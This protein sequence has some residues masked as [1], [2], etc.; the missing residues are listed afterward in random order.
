M[1]SCFE[2]KRRKLKC[3]R[4]TPICSRCISVGNPELC[5]YDPRFA[6]GMDA[7]AAGLTCATEE[8][9]SLSH[10]ASQLPT[11]SLDSIDASLLGENGHPSPW[12]PFSLHL[13]LESA[14]SELLDSE[15]LIDSLKSQVQQHPVP[16]RRNS[17][18]G[19]FRGP[20]H[21]T[22]IISSFQDLYRFMKQT[23]EDHH[24]LGASQWAAY[25]I[26]APQALAP[27]SEGDVEQAMN[28]L[29]PA[30]GR[31]RHL[32]ESYFDH[33][34]GIHALFHTPTFWH[35][36]RSYWD[37]SHN[38]PARFNATLLAVLSCAR[39]LFVDNPLSFDGDSSSA[40]N[41][42]V[43]WLHAVE[44][45]PGY[46]AMKSTTIEAFQLRC[47]VLFSKIQNDIDPD[48]HYTASQT[49]LADAVSNGLHRDWHLLGLDES[50]YERELRRK[51][52]TAIAELDIAACIERGV[53]SM[54][55]NLFTDIGKPRGYN[56]VDYN[57]NSKIEPPDRPDSQLTDSSF[58]KI[59][60]MIRPL[61]YEINEFVNNP[62]KH[63]SLDPHRLAALRMQISEALDSL[64]SWSDPV[65]DATQPNRGLV[66]RAVLELHLHELLLLLHLP[67]A[68][69]K[70][71]SLSPVVDMDFKRFIC[72]RSACT[73][74]KIHELVEQEGFSPIAL[75][76]ASLLRAGLCL[77]LFGGGQLNYGNPCSLESIR[78]SV[79]ES[80]Q[81]SLL[82]RYV[83][84]PK[85]N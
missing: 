15:N 29:L 45:W 25:T 64:P 21:S 41:E 69:E 33:F 78:G 49:L 9:W 22:S 51:V 83:P 12:L 43:E 47:L 1:L 4:E 38:D 77:C 63:K 60:H 36:Y 80:K 61:R 68:L 81:V 20:S 17:L 27:Y 24:V 2:C 71:A 34:T 58:A 23:I 56:D 67:F 73:I 26:S 35:E 74:I 53:P 50:L 66:Y 8:T 65:T 30:E 5:K 59:A 11:P 79:T 40:R 14:S 31:C 75:G 19:R 6:M 39:C 84:L 76:K 72:V 32:A 16:C 46:R 3:G 48:D 62:Q 55:S 57:T 18:N 44:A 28:H 85:P 54:V 52:W 10:S 37:G 13:D 42:A 7:D 70:D 82:Y